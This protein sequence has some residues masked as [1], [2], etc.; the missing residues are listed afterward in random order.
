MNGFVMLPS[1]VL[2][3]AVVV[4]CCSWLACHKYMAVTLVAR[5]SG[6]FLT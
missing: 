2:R 3:Y 6:Y 4:L 1:A 5:Q